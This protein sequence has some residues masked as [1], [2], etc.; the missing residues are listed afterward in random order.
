MSERI[1]VPDSS[2]WCPTPHQ[3]KLFTTCRVHSTLL[4]ITT[5]RMRASI[6]GHCSLTCCSL[7]APLRPCQRVRWSRRQVSVDL[8][9]GKCI[10]LICRPQINWSHQSNIL[11]VLACSR[12]FYDT[13]PHAT[14]SLPATYCIQRR[15]CDI[16]TMIRH[17]RGERFSREKYAVRKLV[18]TCSFYQC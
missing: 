16:L 17:D 10:L 15:T 11:N 2:T 6:S 9:F 14:S 7:A 1:D 4:S 3:C 18:A 5:R 12:Q 8:S 13:C